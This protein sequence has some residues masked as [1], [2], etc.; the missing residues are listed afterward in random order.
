MKNRGKNIGLV[1]GPSLFLLCLCCFHPEGLDPEGRV[2]LATTL[3]VAT[4]WITEAMPIA[5]TALLPM[6]FAA[7][8]DKV[9]I[10][11]EVKIIKN[12]AKQ[13]SF[14]NSSDLRYP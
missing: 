2:V 9:L 8:S 6:V 12:K 3:W 14:L 11:S 7:W 4:W 5:A 10:P 13:L 1:L